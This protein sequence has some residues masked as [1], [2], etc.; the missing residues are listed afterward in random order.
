M[1]GAGFSLTLLYTAVATAAVIGV[2][3]LALK[4]LSR[5]LGAR[6]V[7]EGRLS[8]VQTVP[9]GARERVVVLRDE[10]SEYVVGVSAGGLSLLDKRA[11]SADRAPPEG[12]ER[13]PSGGKLSGR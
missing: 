13:A 4:V 7:R 3:W 1:N 6:P 12:V 9:V 11:R 2:A 8:V 10:T 5:A